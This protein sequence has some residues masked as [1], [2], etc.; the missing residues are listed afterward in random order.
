MTL[1]LV[2]SVA[3]LLPMALFGVVAA[4]APA[5]QFM[6]EQAVTEIREQDLRDVVS[7]LAHDSMAGRDTPSPELDA[8]ARYVASELASTGLDPVFGEFVT[9]YSVEETVLDSA[10][11]DVVFSDGDRL[12]FRRD[13]VPQGGATSP[14]GATGHIVVVHGDPA[15]GTTPLHTLNVGES[16]VA[17]ILPGF[18]RGI[19]AAFWTAVTA[20]PNSP[21]A[22]LLVSETPDSAW[23]ARAKRMLEPSHRLAGDTS[24]SIPIIEIRPG[25]LAPLLNAHGFDLSAAMAQVEEPIAVTSLRRRSPR[26]RPDLRRTNVG[27]PR[28]R[29]SSRGRRGSIE[30]GPPCHVRSPGP[31]G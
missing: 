26:T 21:R 25:A 23:N 2:R 27:C 29:R 18:D 4:C 11:T 24:R 22:F 5:M 14:E 10:H 12:A 19:G 3:G 13:I 20:L 1:D 8:A 31:P 30:Q 16:I 28:G 9:T 6:P 15:S 7:V 17:L